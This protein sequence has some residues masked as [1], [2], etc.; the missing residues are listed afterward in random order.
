MPPASAPVV[1]DQPPG[2][3][4][5]VSF[6]IGALVQRVLAPMTVPYSMPGTVDYIR[7]A[8]EPTKALFAMAVHPWVRACVRAKCDDV[9]GLPIVAVEIGDDGKEKTTTDHPLLA[10]LRQAGTLFVAGKAVS[11]TVFIRQT[12]ADLVLAANFYWYTHMEDDRIVAIHRLHPGHVSAKIRDGIQ[13]GWNYGV[14]QS[15][16]LGVVFHGHDISCSDQLDSIYGET[17]LRTLQPG[18]DAVKAA[19]AHATKTANRTRPDLFVSLSKEAGVDARIATT[20][21]DG[22]EKRME[23]GH[24]VSVMGGGA[25]ATPH[26]W[27]PRDVDMPGLATDVRNETLAVLRVPPTRAGIPAANYAT[28][29]AELRDYWGA[30]V[31]SDLQIIAD[32][33][34]AI[35]RLMGGSISTRIRFDVSRVEALQTSYDQMQARAGFWKTVMGAKSKDAAEYEGFR[36]APV[37]NDSEGTQPSSRPAREVDDQPGRQSAA[38]LTMWLSQAAQRL[39]GGGAEREVEAL[40]LTGALSLALPPDRARAL[41]ESVAPLVCETANH[42]G[43]GVVLAESYAFSADFARRMAA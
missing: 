19:R 24:T 43:E 34:S 13:V 27:T 18:L 37:G 38:V 12:E 22:I 30:L 42:A 4:A 40:L 25:V 16:P 35:A 7:P 39:Q 8:F 32:V 2:F 31:V 26:S 6:S 29:K 9:G 33:L 36:D 41:A 21:A 5:R 23:E 11:Q 14:M 10:L 1:S 28:S 17:P 20:I 3:M 15:Y